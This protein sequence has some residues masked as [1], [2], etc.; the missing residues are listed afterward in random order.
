MRSPFPDEFAFALLDKQTTASTLAPEE[1]ALATQ[2]SSIKRRSEFLLG[3][4]AASSVL[5]ALG[6]Q[7][8]TP[9]IIRG[10]HG[11]PLW[12]IGVVGS[13]SHTSGYSAAV[14]T[15]STKWASVGIDI[16]RKRKLRANILS[17]IATTNETRWAKSSRLG[18]E[19]A[20]LVLFSAKE[21]VYKAAYPVIQR[22]FGFQEGLIEFNDRTL[23]FSG[24]VINKAQQNKREVE[25]T[26][27]VLVEKALILAY[28]TV[29]N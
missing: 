19:L 1:L 18:D 7:A 23:T 25:F 2:M 24:C 6:Y 26:G 11:Q 14:A 15:N 16:E 8:P 29:A 17:R 5:L 21:A 3:R 10:N 13:I 28:V 9:A 20:S 22:W 4:A 27:G 12:P